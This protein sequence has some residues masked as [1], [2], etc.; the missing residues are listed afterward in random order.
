MAGIIFYSCRMLFLILSVEATDYPVVFKLD[1]KSCLNNI[2]DI[3]YSFIF[4][5]VDKNQVIQVHPKHLCF[6][7]RPSGIVVTGYF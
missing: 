2:S 3:F 4:T 7:V 1:P 5:K 6:R